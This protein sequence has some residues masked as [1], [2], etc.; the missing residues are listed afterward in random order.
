MFAKSIVV[1]SVKTEDELEQVYRFRYR[2][3]VEELGRHPRHAD[4]A[5]RRFRHPLD[6]FGVNFAAYD[7]TRIR[8]VI[9][10]NSGTD[11]HF[12]LFHD[13]YELDRGAF[14]H[15]ART[16]IT[17]GLLVE[18]SARGATVAMQLAI[19]CFEH[20][21]RRGERWN[22]IDCLPT[23]SPIFIKLGYV[24][25]LP[26]AI[27]PEYPFM[28]KRLRLDGDDLDHMGEV[29]SPFLRR[30][31]QILG[32]DNLPSPHNQHNQ[33]DNQHLQVPHGLT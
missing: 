7:G 27:H 22:F 17:T 30:A 1:K 5:R 11:G 25:H 15:P 12:G 31:V 2:V 14:D 23:L 18:R 32:I 4:S 6:E 28:V 24:D 33:V 16:S 26:D 20:G 13:F 29:R 10:H 9:R 19:A 3:C 21:L 8:G